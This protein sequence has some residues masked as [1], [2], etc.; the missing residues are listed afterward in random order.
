MNKKEIFV[1]LARHPNI[2]EHGIQLVTRCVLCGDSMKNPNKKRLGIKCDYTNPTE[3]LLYN[4]FNC[5]ESG[6]VSSQM[7]RDIG[8][9]DDELIQSVRQIN[10]GALSS[11]GNVKVSKYKNNKTIDVVIPPLTN[12][13]THMTKLQYLFSRIGKPESMNMENLKRLKIVWSLKDFLELNGV[14]PINQYTDLLDR[15]YIGFLSARNEYIIFRDIT[16]KNKMRYVKYNIFGVFDNSNAFYTIQNSID[17]LSR[18]DIHIIA[19]E[20]TFDILSLFYNVYDGDI[21]NKIF[22]A[23]C[24]GQYRNVLMYY[25]NKG[26]VGRNI[27]IDIYRDSDNDKF[28]NYKKLKMELKPYTKNY[29]V[30]YNTLSKDFG[31]PK[32]MIDIDIFM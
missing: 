6:V 1:R 24:N 32:E 9:N 23:T 31:V 28:M 29:H 15:D 26:L 7:L 20:G 5:G 17:L 21:H 11:E 16:G 22:C 19:A 12:N 14:S 4:C 25:I 13:P 27:C 3:P 18:E 30:Y 8:V 10:K 2:E